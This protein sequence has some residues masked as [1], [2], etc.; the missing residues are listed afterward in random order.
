MNT[1][2]ADL[3]KI[4][5]DSPSFK[6]NYDDLETEAKELQEGLV[7]LKDAILS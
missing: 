7:I 5:A 6:R 1:P 2:D 3:L 4:M